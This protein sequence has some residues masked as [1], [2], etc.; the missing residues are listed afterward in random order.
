[1]RKVVVPLRKTSIIL[2][3]V[4]CLEGALMLQRFKRTAVSWEL[5]RAKRFLF[6]ADEQQLA[7]QEFYA[8]II[9]Q[10]P[11]NIIDVGANA[12]AKT[13]IFQHFAKRV[14]AIDPDLT[15]A[16]TLR[17]RFKWR[18]GVTVRRCAI[19]SA[20]GSILFYQFGPGSAFNTAD[21][22][23]SKEYDKWQ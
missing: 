5:R 9:P 23:M 4:R 16:E 13:E 11:G 1:M 3:Q 17:R 6:G 19:T 2:V 18:P 20:S 8:S 12:G 14:V 21:S 15:S 7:E 22:G 10:G